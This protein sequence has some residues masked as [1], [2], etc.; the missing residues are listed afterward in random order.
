MRKRLP[1]RGSGGTRMKPSRVA[2]VV[3]S[4]IATRWPVFVW[5]PPGCGKSSLV[6]GVA[7]SAGMPVI[8]IRAS[9]LDPT[10]LRGIPAVADGRAVW[11]PPSF[12][13]RPGD[14]AGI[15]F[16]DELNAAPPLVQASLYQL[17]L[18][19]RVG[20]YQLPEGWAIVAAG[21]RAEDR[22][23]VFR[24]PAAL[25]NRFIH[26][27]FEVDYDDW[28]TWA[29]G[30]G[31]H[32][33]VISFLGLRRELLHDMRATDRAFPTP[34]SWEMASTAIK[35]FK[36]VS[37]CIDV[38]I[39]TVGEGPAMELASHAQTAMTLEQIA[40]IVAD[41]R[42]AEIPKGLG[43]LYA[44]VSYLVQTIGEPPTQEA[45]EVLLERIPVE[46]AVLLARDTL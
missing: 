45:C 18:D 40:A 20:E 1:H 35:Q 27:D 36:S 29:H 34:R 33:T 21:N 5:G 13:P 31:V 24:M 3:H 25:S 15:L 43:D 11:C 46:M 10:D 30:A 41:P 23:V 38:L 16:F 12:L 8:D 28:R 44:L 32:P 22:S 6:R 37:A 2:D 14:P 17:T 26:V 4:L 19:R 9:L 7:A 39:G 42:G